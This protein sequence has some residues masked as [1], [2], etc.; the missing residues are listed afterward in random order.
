MDANKSFPCDVCGKSFQQKS[1]MITHKRILTGEKPYKCDTCEKTFN[2]GSITQV[3]KRINVIF[4][5][6]LSH[7]IVA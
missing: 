6:S 7:R 4:V 3:K 1:N 5:K 2:S